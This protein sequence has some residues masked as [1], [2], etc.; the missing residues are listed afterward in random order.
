MDNIHN[1]KYMT[2]LQKIFL[3]IGGVAIIGLGV[4]VY[5]QM[6]GSIV[7]AQTTTKGTSVPEQQVSKEAVTQVT[8]V[9]STPEAVADDILRE[10]DADNSVLNEEELGA[11][12]AIEAEGSVVS[13]FGTVYDAN[14][15]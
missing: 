12:S 2:G 7:P 5:R 8:T 3:G 10:V 4:V 9:P 6:S 1:K 13:D 15:N 14:E 11:S